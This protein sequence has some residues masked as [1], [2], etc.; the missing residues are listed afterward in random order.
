MDQ[1]AL[2]LNG[3]SEYHRVYDA[4]RRDPVAFWRDAATA[5]DWIEPPQTIF[6]P[7]AGI[8]GRWFTDGVCNTAFNCL[9]RQVRDGR[10]AQAAILYDSPVA[11]LKRSISYAELTD[12][13]AIFAQVLKER[14][15]EAGD[16]V[17]IYM[18]M[19]PE[20]VIAMLA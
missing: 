16:R 1:T 6:D 9:D 18:P 19:I 3:A 12:E 10:G 17:L 5:I 11:G 8:Y 2:S 7:D 20:A 4:W 15:V 13:V 14:G